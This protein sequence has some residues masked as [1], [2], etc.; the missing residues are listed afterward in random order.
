[1][2]IGVGVKMERLWHSDFYVNE[3]MLIWLFIL[4]VKQ[5]KVRW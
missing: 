5:D 1:L 4:L 2:E 3:T